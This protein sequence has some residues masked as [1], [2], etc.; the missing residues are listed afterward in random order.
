MAG[1]FTSVNDLFEAIVRED[2]VVLRNFENLAETL[3]NSAHPD[4]D[5]LCRDPRR[6]TSRLHLKHR[7]KIPDG[8]HYKVQVGGK[9]VAV[10]LRH[11]GDGYLDPAW[12]ERILLHRMRS[13]QGFYI[14]REK[15]HMYSLLYHVL[16]QKRAVADDYRKKLE[17]YFGD[18]LFAGE[19]QSA[20]AVLERYMSAHNYRFTYPTYPLGIFN[21]EAV[22]GDLMEHN[23]LKRLLHTGAGM[24][25][26]KKMK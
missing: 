26:G 1:A 4:I 17:G 24:V 3:V 25:K 14:P 19:R 13:R 22:S 5:F 12:E 6:M 15:D 10:D 20:L 23:I 21:T 16:I 8:I 9:S 18:G 11:V 2:Y 7:G